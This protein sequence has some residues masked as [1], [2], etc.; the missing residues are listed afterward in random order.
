M[1]MVHALQT[2]DAIGL[3]RPAA[4]Q[5]DF[6]LEALARSADNTIDLLVDMQNFELINVESRCI[7]DESFLVLEVIRYKVFSII[8]SFWTTPP[9]T[10]L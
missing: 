1:A 5:L 3:A 10:K 7:V 9:M 8:Q 4:H 6:H 2:V